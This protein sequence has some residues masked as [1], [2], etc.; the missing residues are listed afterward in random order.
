MRWVDDR[1]DEVIMSL[2]TGS[3]GLQPI[4]LD[5]RHAVNPRLSRTLA[6]LKYVATTEEL[7]PVA[8][9]PG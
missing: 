6:N 4:S 8:V 9:S 2:I 3:A 7:F 5:V 1:A